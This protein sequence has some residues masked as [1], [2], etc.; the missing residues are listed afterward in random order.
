MYNAHWPRIS[1]TSVNGIN[2]H[3]MRIQF[4]STWC[5]FWCAS[6]VNTPLFKV[7]YIYSFTVNAMYIMYVYKWVSSLDVMIFEVLCWLC[8][9]AFYGPLT[10]ILATSSLQTTYIKAICP[11]FSA[12]FVSR[13]CLL[14]S[15]S[16][17][18]GHVWTLNSNCDGSDLIIQACVYKNYKLTARYIQNIY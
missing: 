6:S 1:I 3:W 18:A 10:P 2:A 4:A 7:G 16:N 11:A 9:V 8:N 15:P 5:A 12:I 13:H 17:I 14:N